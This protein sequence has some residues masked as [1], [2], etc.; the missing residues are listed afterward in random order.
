M[1]C[2][3]D[4]G[5]TSMRYALFENDSLVTQ[6]KVAG[7]NFVSSDMNTVFSNLPSRE[8]IDQLLVFGAGISPTSD[9]TNLEKLLRNL[10]GPLD[11]LSID[12]DLTLAG[13]AFATSREY[14]T[15]ILGT[16]SHYG[17]FTRGKLHSQPIAGG[18]LLGDLGSGYAIGRLVLQR[19]ISKQ[20]SVKEDVILES[21]F[22]I[23]RATLIQTVYNQSDP[24]RYI[25][26]FANGLVDLESETKNNILQIIFF[27]YF[28]NMLQE[29]PSAKYLTINFVGGI[30]KAFEAELRAAGGE[31]QLQIGTILNE[32]FD[33]IESIYNFVITTI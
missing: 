21:K 5:A 7:G 13:M 23:S 31:H 2:I 22:D 32:P 10:F 19:Y 3:I 28:K 4:C 17:Q 18:Y 14:L 20:F 9:K 8:T 33:A 15:C 24:K 12:G 26:A 11:Y 27:E 29:M 1:L 25:A 16:G 6:G 30:A